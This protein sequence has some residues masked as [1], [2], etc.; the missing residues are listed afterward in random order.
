[1]KK[2]EGQRVRRVSLKM[3]VMVKD[4]AMIWQDMKCG[5]WV[6]K[7]EVFIVESKLNN[8]KNRYILTGKGY[9]AKEDYGNGAIF[10][11]KADLIR[12]DN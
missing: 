10:V 8:H 1:M 2:F 3:K 9:G 11:N 7:G 6:N 5:N 12:F 4:G